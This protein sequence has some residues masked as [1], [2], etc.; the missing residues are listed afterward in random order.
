MN[1]TISGHHLTV[2]KG[3]REKITQRAQILWGR[4]RNPVQISVTLSIESTSAKS[5]RHC[6][7]ISFKDSVD[8]PRLVH[9][10]G[11]DMYAIIDQGFDTLNEARYGGRRQH[12]HVRAALSLLKREQGLVGHVLTV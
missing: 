10:S 2:T 1:L 8:S 5:Q 12:R 9:L 3:L 7:N 4:A 6:V 11:E